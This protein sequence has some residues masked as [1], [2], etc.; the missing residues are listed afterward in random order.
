MVHRLLCSANASHWLTVFERNY[1]G[2]GMNLYYIGRVSRPGSSV[3]CL[4][5][6][7]CYTGWIVLPQGLFY[8][9]VLGDS[10]IVVRAEVGYT[11][12]DGRACLGHHWCYDT[13]SK[14]T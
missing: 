13:V 4:S 11:I 8:M 2:T 12:G 3:L 7:G 1:F 9:A 5:A 14:H 10:N 6:E